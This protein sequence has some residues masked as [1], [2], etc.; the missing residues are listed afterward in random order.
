MPRAA[1]APSPRP[2]GQGS[3]PRHFNEPPLYVII[4]LVHPYPLRDFRRH[5]V[6]PER[7]TIAT[8]MEKP[9]PLLFLGQAADK[10]TL[11]L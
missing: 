10:V 4:F 2:K 8:A 9:W 5:K 7:S 11:L 6:T 1:T 3:T